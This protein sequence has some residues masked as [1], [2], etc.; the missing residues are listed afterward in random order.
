[1]VLVTLSQ[2]LTE[3]DGGGVIGLNDEINN[4]VK[5]EKKLVRS[6][7]E[8]VSVKILFGRV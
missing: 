5:K 8:L 1:M 6:A 3:G 4:C 7:L 2:L